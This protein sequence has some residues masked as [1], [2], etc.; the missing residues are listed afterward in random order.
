[1]SDEF[2]FDEA[3]LLELR[4][5]FFEQATEVIDSLS[6][7]IIKV[8]SDPADSESLRSIRRAV[9]TLKGDSTAFGF[10]D[11]THLAHKYEDALDKV[12]AG[13]GVASRA[14]I[15]LLLAGADALA[16]MINHYRGNGPMPETARLIEGLSQLANETPSQEPVVVT[17]VV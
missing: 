7:M 15:D 16:A 14:L 2:Q 10:S 12:R 3:E 8:E 6:E 11:L 13:S 5:M 4:G 17:E 1:M 9:H